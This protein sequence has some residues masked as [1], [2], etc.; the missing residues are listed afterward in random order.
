MHWRVGSLRTSRLRTPMK[1]VINFQSFSQSHDS[2]FFNRLRRS[3]ACWGMLFDRSPDL[4]EED[5]RSVASRF[6]NSTKL[7][8][9]QVIVCRIL[10]LEK[11]DRY[12]SREPFKIRFVLSQRV[13]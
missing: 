12:S 7:T 8:D 1:S 6:S 4:A 13:R 10:T 9:V 11:Y 3:S 5:D 2:S